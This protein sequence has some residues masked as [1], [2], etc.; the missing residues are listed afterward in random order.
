MPLPRARSVLLAAAAAAAAAL[1]ALV[2]AAYQS[3]MSRARQRI[4]SGSDVAQTACG[5]I[6]YAA[7]GE[8]PAILL[9]HGAGGG[10]DQVLEP[11][12]FGYLRTPQRADATA[13]AQA[14]AH[15]CLL[16]FL[17]VARAAVIGVSAGGPSAMQFA[18]RHGE[19]C[20][21]LVLLVPLA[22]APERAGQAA[23]PPA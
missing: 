5:A 11:A 3:D 15:A 19:R 8:G 14:D 10:F 12:R 13:A 7:V 23:P 21:A 18:L 9:V 20:T 6:E 16:D 17:K 4:A 1:F 22:Y 2:F